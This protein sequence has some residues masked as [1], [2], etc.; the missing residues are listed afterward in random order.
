MPGT[1]LFVMKLDDLPH[2]CHR[3]GIADLLD[4]IQILFEE[5]RF[6]QPDYSCQGL[7]HDRNTM[8]Q[9][10][11]RKFRAGT[12]EPLAAFIGEILIRITNYI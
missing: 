2:F 3:G 6:L 10:H 7:P 1:G 5:V 11:F 8:P 4:Q 9:H 12:R